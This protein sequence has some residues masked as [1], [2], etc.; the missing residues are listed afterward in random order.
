LIC[1]YIF[2]YKIFKIKKI[3]DK[4]EYYFLVKYFLTHFILKYLKHEY[5]RSL[6]VIEKKIE[7]LYIIYKNYIFKFKNKI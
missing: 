3:K 1:L 7:T 5:N 6:I 4:I 2:I